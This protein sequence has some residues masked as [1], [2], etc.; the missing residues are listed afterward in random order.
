MN[1]IDLAA[2]AMVMANKGGRDLEVR[3][4]FVPAGRIVRSQTLGQ[5]PQQDPPTFTAGIYEVGAEEH[6]ILAK[7]GQV[8]EQ[9]FGQLAMMIIQRGTQWFV[10]GDKPGLAI[11]PDDD[12]EKNSVEDEDEAGTDGDDAPTDPSDDPAS[13]DALEDDAAGEYG[14]GAENAPLP[15]PVEKPGVS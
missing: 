9:V 5:P 2:Q 13:R 10:P 12:E 7:G 4:R 1:P 8:P 3:L 11:V 15:P 14:E 6:V